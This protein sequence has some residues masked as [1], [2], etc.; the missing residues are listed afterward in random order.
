MIMSTEGEERRN[1]EEIL[2]VYNIYNDK[3][4]PSSVFGVSWRFNR[5]LKLKIF[6]HDSNLVYDCIKM[7]KI[8]VIQGSVKIIQVYSTYIISSLYDLR[9]DYKDSI[10]NDKSMDYFPP[11]FIITDEAHNFAPVSYTHLTL[12]T[13]P[14]V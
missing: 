8:A 14:Y 3:C 10:I 1:L 11:F 12:P 7:G 4:P 5:L 9:R 6:E 2:K 13:T